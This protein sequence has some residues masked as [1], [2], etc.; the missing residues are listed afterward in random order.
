MDL[1]HDFKEFIAKEALFS[2]GDR[3]LLAVS[4][5]LDSA[6]LCELCR[7]AEYDAVLAHCNFALRG[8][9]SDRD[10]LF[11]RQLAADYGWE[12]AVKTFDTAAYAAGHK[13]SVQVAARQLRYDWFLGLVADGAAHY[14]VTAHHLDDNIETMLMNFFKGTGIAGLRGML[15]KQGKIVRPL[16]FAAREQ[17]AEFAREAGVSWV[18]D[19]SNR[20]DKYTRNYF[21]HQVIP[22]IGQVY[23]GALSNLAGNLAR[24]RDI[25]VI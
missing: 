23:P 24:F 5:G 22:L 6:V 18:E 16:L 1:L 8:G 25:E 12:V 15:P 21:R 3:L 14:V 20:S 19:S 7:R 11:V 10:E 4:G 13:L 17:L 2:R 9:E